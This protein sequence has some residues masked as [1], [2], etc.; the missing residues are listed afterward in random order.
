M[1]TTDYRV[2]EAKKKRITN[3]SWDHIWCRPPFLS[4]DI[5]DLCGKP[6][7]DAPEHCTGPSYLRRKEP[8]GSAML[9]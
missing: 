3:H 6:R 4:Y 1:S 7:Y 5:C 2:T 8:G 9:D